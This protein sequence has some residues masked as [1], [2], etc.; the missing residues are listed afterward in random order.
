MKRPAVELDECTACGQI[1]DVDAA[2]NP[3]RR[4]P[5]CGPELIYQGD[6]FTV[7]GK[8]DGSEATVRLNYGA[9]RA[10]VARVSMMRLRDEIDEWLATTVDRS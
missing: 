5:A 4:C 7:L 3:L 9:T 10:Y 8:V 6:E 1:Y 2:P